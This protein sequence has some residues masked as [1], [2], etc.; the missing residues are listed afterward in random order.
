MSFFKDKALRWATILRREN[1]PILNSF[2]DCIRG[3]RT[4][5]GVQDCETIVANGKLCNIKQQRFKNVYGYINEFKRI[6]QYSN[7]NESAKIY[8]FLQGLHY[9]M[10][11][12]LAIVNPNPDDLD[13]LYRNVINIES[14]TKRVSISEHYYNYGND[15]H[16]NTSDQHSDPMDVDLMRI[17]SGSRFS[18][19]YAAP[20]KN[21]YI[22]N[23]HPHYEEKKK[24]LCFICKKPGHLQFNCP[25]KKKLRN[26][27]ATHASPSNTPTS[28]TL[29]RIMK[30]DD[31]MDS[32]QI[33]EIINNVNIFPKRKNNILE[34][35]VKPED[36]EEIKAT[37]LIDSGSDLNYVHPDL[38]KKYNI[39]T[40]EITQFRVTGLGRDVSIVESITDKCIVWMVISLEKMI[41]SLM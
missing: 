26:V 35:Y 1:K 16:T 24:G 33:L 38:V 4:Q 31:S 22:D 3:L 18:H 32:K 14:L 6:S 17:R 39:K 37:V 11:E 12:H 23:S 30:I 36:K 5:F 20:K 25:E 21:L 8:M 19:Q 2:E 7:F 28:V 9:K 41:M 29:R 40:K 10:R 34:F 13:R 15:S 27:K